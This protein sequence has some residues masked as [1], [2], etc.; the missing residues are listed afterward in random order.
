MDAAARFAQLVRRPP[1]EVPL[2]E[3]ALCIA[4]V[5]QPDLDVDRQLRRLDELA[6]TCA[7]ASIDALCDRLFGELGLR[8]AVEDYEDPRHSFV[9]Q[10]L[11]RR[12]GIPI[13]LAVV[14]MEVGRRLGVDLEGVGMPGHFLLRDPAEPDR[15][16][17]VYRRGARVGPEG[18]RAIYHGVFGAGAP[19][20]TELL[21]P[22]GSPDILSRML[23]NLTGS[24]RARGDRIGRLWVARLRAVIPDRPAAE[25]V[26]VADELAQLGPSDQAAR[27]LEDLARR[28]DLDDHALEQLHGRALELRARLN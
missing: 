2:D 20:S 13:T 28:P 5:G 6:S 24:Y 22:V 8:G 19:W 17:D 4:A 27:L 10:V 14:T 25:V 3:G 18:C 9:D 1:G 23:T 16:L 12:T 26:A 21:A 15:Y 11:D 7:A